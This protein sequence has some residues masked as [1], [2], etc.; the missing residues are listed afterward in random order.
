VGSLTKDP[1][2]KVFKD[3]VS[4]PKCKMETP[5]CPCFIGEYYKTSPTVKICYEFK[6]SPL[7][8]AFLLPVDIFTGN[9]AFWIQNCGKKLS[10]RSSVYKRHLMD[11][12]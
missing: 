11:I 5:L 6:A 10:L 8:G 4:A 7:G 9:S 2:V 1:E 12:P 3:L